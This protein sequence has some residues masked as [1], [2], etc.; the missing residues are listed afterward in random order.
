MFEFN[1]LFHVILLLSYFTICST[2]LTLHL[3]NNLTHT[4]GGNKI[5]SRP[6]ENIWKTILM[7]VVLQTFVYILFV[8]IWLADGNRSSGSHPPVIV[9]FIRVQSY[10][11][12]TSTGDVRISEDVN[13]S[14][15]EGKHV[16][17]VEDLIDTGA[18]MTRYSVCTY[19]VICMNSRVTSLH[20]SL[21]CMLCLFT[22]LNKCN[23]RIHRLMEYISQRVNTASL[24]Y[25][26]RRLFNIHISI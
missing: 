18:T 2:V 4:I 24:R 6:L 3:H 1:Y 15:Y 26:H 8:T 11:N 22:F 21:Y 14:V 17:I 13:L 9:E 23:I 19:N 12:T 20:T 16:I 10:H 5:L 7:L 25:V